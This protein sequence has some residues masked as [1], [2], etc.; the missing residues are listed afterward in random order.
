MKNEINKV[1][2]F[3]YFSGR[4]TALEKQMIED[5]TAKSSNLEQ[6][7]VWLHEWE[8]ENMQYHVEVDQGL[9]RHWEKMHN[10]SPVE[11]EENDSE[12]EEPKI[13]S[14]LLNRF[15]WLVAATI[16][17]T[18]SSGLWIF[19]DQIQ[20]Q[21]Y[22]TGFSETKKLQ[23]EDGSRIVLNSNSSLRVPRFGFGKKTREVFLIGEADFDVVHTKD[24][25]KFVVKT[26]KN[27]DV[28]VLGTKFN[29]YSRPRGTN[30]MLSSGKVQLQY[31]EGYAKKLLNMKPGDYVSM[32]DKG[33][34]NIQRIKNPQKFSSWKAHK[35]IFEKTTLLEVSHLLEDN[36]GL[37]VQIPDTNLAQLTISGSFTARN[38]EELIENLTGDSG[39]KFIRSEDEK[40]MVLSY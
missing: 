7:F 30:V 15:N 22:K 38:G 37:T 32:N 21:V 24:D 20:Y 25:Q 16:L 11:F 40:T 4:A 26:V 14:F 29:V 18:I 23:L 35:F 31:Q 5:W 9:K 2:I 34:A 19:R 27:L 28:I 36:F 8:Q 39:L 33:Q 10:S 3:N 1:L 6:F 13:R 12:E 17:I